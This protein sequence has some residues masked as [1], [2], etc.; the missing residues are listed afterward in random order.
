MD[1]GDEQHWPTGQE[2]LRLSVRHQ[3]TLSNPSK[4]SQDVPGFGGPGIEHA[5]RQILAE[6]CPWQLAHPG[7]NQSISLLHVVS[8][9]LV[10]FPSLASLRGKDQANPL[11]WLTL[12]PCPVTFAGSRPRLSSLSITPPNLPCHVAGRPTHGGLA[13]PPFQEQHGK[14]LACVARAHCARVWFS[15]PANPSATE[16]GRARVGRA[17][18]GRI[19][20]RLIE[21]TNLLSPEPATRGEFVLPL[22]A[23]S[24]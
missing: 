9:W 8:M 12:P 13:E 3:A 17:L 6:A 22:V 14:S 16:C 21:L 11:F 7:K 5:Q 1:D 23:V 24:R 10:A 2:A 15:I 18:V 20:C 19:N 4:T